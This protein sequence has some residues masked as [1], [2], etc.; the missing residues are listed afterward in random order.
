MAKK[1]N[2][3]NLIISIC[4]VCKGQVQLAGKNWM[5]INKIDKKNLPVGLPEECCPSCLMDN[6]KK[7]SSLTKQKLAQ[8]IA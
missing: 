4:S 1:Q 5:E 6:I 2:R 8:V 7:Y 3:Q